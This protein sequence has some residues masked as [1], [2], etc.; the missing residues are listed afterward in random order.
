MGNKNSNLQQQENPAK[1]EVNPHKEL[2]EKI[3]SVDDWTELSKSIE[4]SG[5][6]SLTTFA[7]Y[8]D[9]PKHEKVKDQ[10]IWRSCYFCRA[11]LTLCF[12]T[13]NDN[14]RNTEISYCKKCNFLLKHQTHFFVYEERSKKLKEIVE[15]K[16]PEMTLLMEYCNKN[17]NGG[18]GG[19]HLFYARYIEDLDTSGN[20]NPNVKSTSGDN[21]DICGA[22]KN[23]FKRD[24]IYYDFGEHYYCDNCHLETVERIINRDEEEKEKGALDKLMDIFN[25]KITTS[26]L[27]KSDSSCR[28]NFADYAC[29]EEDFK[30]PDNA[31]K[32]EK[33]PICH[34]SYFLYNTTQ[35]EVPYMVDTS[36]NYYYCVECKMHFLSTYEQEYN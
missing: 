11:S 21:C 20:E 14:F 5:M 1:E 12:L 33:C 6:H 10:R 3:K 25:N 7:K 34:K 23:Y 4:S 8:G 18:K 19:D 32:K 17:E 35:P 27:Y 28:S 29:Y 9:E 13:L 15:S 16:T 36:Y 2:K 31:I 22:K 26:T 24:G 30:I